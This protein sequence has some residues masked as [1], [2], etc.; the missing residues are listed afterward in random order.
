M[1]RKIS[2]YMF[3]T[4]NGV[5]LMESLLFSEPDREGLGNVRQRVAA[6]AD[7]NCSANRKEEVEMATGKHVALGV[8]VWEKG[9]GSSYKV[10]H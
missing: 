3:V 9:T 7:A 8:C 10:L 4:E 5:L 6:V 1:E 2:Q